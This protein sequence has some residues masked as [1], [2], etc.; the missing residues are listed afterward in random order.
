MIDVVGPESRSERTARRAGLERAWP[1]PAR[2]PAQPPPSIDGEPDL[3][4]V[5][6][7]ADPT[8]SD[9]SKSLLF[10]MMLAYG[11]S[12]GLTTSACSKSFLCGRPST[13]VCDLGLSR[14]L[15]MPSMPCL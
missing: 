2:L 8:F 3:F 11:T 9:V 12:Q 7:R 1:C 6:A 14:D 5:T 10:S 13:D 15:S 4:V